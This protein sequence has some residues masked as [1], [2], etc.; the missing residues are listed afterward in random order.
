MDTM[1]NDLEAALPKLIAHCRVNNWEGYEPYDAFNSRI[2]N[3]LPFLNFRFPRL[4]FTQAL[5]RSPIN[6]RRLLLIDKTQN[7]KAIAIFL[8]AFLKLSKL[9]GANQEGYV[10]LMIERLIALRSPVRHW[11]WGY[12]FPWQTRTDLV[13]KWAPNLVC[14]YFAASALLDTYE[15]RHETRCLQMGISAA[16]YMLTDLYWTD[17]ESRFGFSYPLPSSHGQ[18][19]NANFLAAELLC[20]VYKHTG[21]KKFLDPALRIARYSAKKQNADGSWNYGEASSQQWIDNFHT[22]YN[23]GA[24]RSIGRHL[25]TDEFEARVKHG[26]E[27]YRNRFFRDDGAVRYYHD[28]TYPIDAHCIAQS[29]ITLLTFKDLDDSNGRLAEKVFR[30]AMANMWDDRGFFYYRVLRS[31]TI[32]TS[33]MRWTQCWMLLAMVMLAESHRDSKVQDKIA[34]GV[35]E[36]VHS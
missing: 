3:A 36:A 26:F 18:T 28:N 9:E 13:P 27:F 14:T 11:C 32:R 34:T 20:R 5:K 16:E 7:P 6:V 4:A 21:D 30:W 35:T 1:N 24:L 10:D 2:L 29:I 23:L 12:S 15:Q 19:H 8:A 25:E 22:G 33:Y 31:C 17:G